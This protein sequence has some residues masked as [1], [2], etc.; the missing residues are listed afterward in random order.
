ML[1][2]YRE[3]V[4]L[5][6]AALPPAPVAIY[7]PCIQQQPH[8]LDIG[9]IHVCDLHVHKYVEEVPMNILQGHLSLNIH[10]KACVFQYIIRE[11]HYK[12]VSQNM[13]KLVYSV[14]LPL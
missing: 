10:S 2:S 9:N 12:Q 14:T 3:K 6:D 4:F 13:Y 11:S 8:V 5:G 7:S 1:T